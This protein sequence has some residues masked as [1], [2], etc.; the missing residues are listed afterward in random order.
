[1]KLENIILFQSPALSKCSCLLREH[2]SNSLYSQMSENCLAAGFQLHLTLYSYH[3]QQ[4]SEIQGT[5]IPA[6]YSKTMSLSSCVVIE[7]ND[8][9]ATFTSSAGFY[10]DLKRSRKFK[11]RFRNICHQ[12]SLCTMYTVST[13]MV[14]RPLPY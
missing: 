8:R 10:Q 4:W 6:F 2:L 5:D 9:R 3:M 13:P 12:V 11:G 1:M 14:C 7:L